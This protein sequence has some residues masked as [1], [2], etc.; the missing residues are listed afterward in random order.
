[1]SDETPASDASAPPPERGRGRLILAAAGTA[2]IMVWIFARIGTREIFSALHGVDVRYVL[3][4]LAVSYTANTLIGADK[5]RKILDGLGCHISLREALF[6]RLGGAPVRFSFPAKSGELFKALYLRSCHQMPFLR[7]ASALVVDKVL[8][9]WGMLLFLFV[10]L[11]FFHETLPRGS[12]VFPVLFVALPI[13]LWH[14]RKPLYELM[15]RAHPK[16]RHLAEQLLSAF[17][18]M[19]GPRKVGVFAYSVLFQASELLTCYLLCR[20]AHV[21]PQVEFRVML[22]LVPLVVLISS[23]PALT[24]SGIGLREASIVGILALYGYGPQENA[25]AAGILL[26]AVE[27]IAPML[28]G[29]P[30]LPLFL[31]RIQSGRSV[32]PESQGENA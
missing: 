7:G 30:F 8:N 29:V 5:F 19:S 32:A 28:L 14:F 4:A 1:V 27:Y 17:E 3:M 13:L 6:I 25:A 23:L 10:G 11:P 9:M 20:A 12:V 2:V 24:I 22:I 16:V 15:G 21:E 31:K 26:S 18:E